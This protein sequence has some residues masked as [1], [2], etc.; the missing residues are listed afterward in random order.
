MGQSLY[1]ARN[2]PKM[3]AF[4]VI[5]F[6]TEDTVLAAA[7]PRQF[8][9]SGIGECRVLAS[10][11]VLQASLTP[12]PP[13]LALIDCACHDVA[14]AGLTTLR[15]DHPLMALIG[16]GTSEQAEYFSALPLSAFVKRPVS[17]PALLRS[18]EHLGYARAMSAG[19]QA[20]ALFHNAQFLPAA[21][22]IR[23]AK[24]EL[25]LT[26][27]ESAILLCLY[28]HRHGWLPRQQ[29]LEEVWGYSDAIATHTLETHLYRLRAKLRDMLGN[30]DSIVTRQGAYQLRL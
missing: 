12:Q 20:L 9:H 15:H 6:L 23:H 5:T 17:I 7:I 19:Q 18:V 8:V 11:D 13:A 3:E 30:E 29:L 28:H 24:G 22:T 2:W 21:K 25:E 4:T 26:D 14:L 10:W 16:I 1:N 27:K